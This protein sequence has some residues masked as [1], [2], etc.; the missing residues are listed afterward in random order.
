[1][2]QRRH[3]HQKLAAARRRHKARTELKNE[4]KFL[5]HGV[6]N[7]R[8]SQELL[9]ESERA[10][11]IQHSDR[12]VAT[13]VTLIY[14]LYPTMCSAAFS[15]TACQPIGSSR[16]Y[17]QQDLEVVCYGEVHLAWFMLLCVPALLSLVV[18]IP[19]FTFFLLRRSNMLHRRTRY[20]YGILTIGFQP[21]AY[22]WELCIAGR[23]LLTS[24]IGVYMLRSDPSMQALTSEILV[25][26][27]LVLHLTV[28]PYHE[29]TPK[30]NSLQNAETFALTV[31]F[32]TL[33]CGI[34]LT[35]STV[36][37]GTFY[38]FV[39]VSTNCMFLATASWWYFVLMRMDLENMIEK[40]E[41]LHWLSN[42]CLMC[43]TALFPDWEKE[44]RIAELDREEAEAVED[45]KHMDLRWAARIK[46]IAHRWVVSH[47]RRKIE[48]HCN[49]VPAGR[50]PIELSSAEHA[51]KRA[52][53]I[54]RRSEI[55]VK[56][57]HEG[58][59][60]KRRKS[61]K[62]LEMRRR[63]ASQKQ[64]RQGSSAFIHFVV[65]EHVELTSLGFKLRW[66]HN[67]CV[68][69]NLLPM[70]LGARQGLKNGSI[71][72]VA[73]GVPMTDEK[74]FSSILFKR[75]LEMVFNVPIE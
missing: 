60:E 73:G 64:L 40:M 6:S 22:Y 49:I 5:A 41:E 68:L 7:S 11:N 2:L 67:K 43:L 55:A 21:Y 74:L 62:R 46:E 23:K 51:L 28:E 70:K 56:H 59:K 19:L 20:R 36:K 4:T 18:G 66:V 61:V 30:K 75:P 53:S 27:A 12:V 13:I 52:N 15:L 47:R 3:C 33:V 69:Y 63:T 35:E 1:M 54:E 25:V 48:G 14:L 44:G 65:P 17:L 45:L 29:V 72:L 16:S 9:E 38:T 10:A 42:N 24:A 50:G 32:I 57:F 71:L 34:V 31:A 58:L 26:I 39:I 37:Y 8:R